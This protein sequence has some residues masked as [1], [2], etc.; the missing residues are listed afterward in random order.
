MNK[1]KMIEQRPSDGMDWLYEYRGENDRYFTD[2]VYRP[3]GT[4][5]WAECTQAERE[6]WEEAHKPEVIEPAEVIE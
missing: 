6:E 3:E 5:P 4:E 1:I 2:V